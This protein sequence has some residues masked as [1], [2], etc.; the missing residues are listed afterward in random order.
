MRLMPVTLSLAALLAGPAAAQ[1]VCRP[2]AGS[3]EVKVFGTFAVPLA[4]GPL[5]GPPSLELGQ[6]RIQLEGSYLPALDAAARTPTICRPGKG[7]EN[8]D[9]LFALP[10]PRLLLGGP[11]RFQLELSWIPPIRI[12][13][14]K[15]NLVGLA[16]ARAIPLGRLGE[17]EASLGLRVHGTLGVIRAPITCDDPELENPN[18]ECYQGTRSDD[19]YHPNVFGAEGSLGWALARGRFRPYVGGGLNLLRPRF[20]VNFVNRFGERD[21]TRVEAN[22]TRGVVFGGATW[23]AT[24]RVGITGEVYA[25]PADAVTGRL[26]IGY[27]FH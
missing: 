19:R 1:T 24:P 15:A 12:N 22:L 26:A 21:S 13:G 25:A 8:T 20:Q 3:N 27:G 7:P 9:F 11:A 6:G 18:S 17:D 10:R 14:A 16:L 2:P 4:F 23:L 5:A